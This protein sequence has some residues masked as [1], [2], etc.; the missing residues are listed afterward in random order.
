TEQI[1]ALEA[2]SEPDTMVLRDELESRAVFGAVFCA[3][4]TSRNRT[5]VRLTLHAALTAAELDHLEAV[6]AEVA[7][8]VRPWTWPIARRGRGSAGD[9]SP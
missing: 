9:Q 4:A 6:T 5:M 1:I 8:R 3:P 2:G 7:Q